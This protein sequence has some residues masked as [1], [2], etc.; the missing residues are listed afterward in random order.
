[1]RQRAIRLHRN[2]LPLGARN[3]ASA[4][5]D[6][7]APSTALALTNTLTTDYEGSSRL[8]LSYSGSFS[9][10]P[11]AIGAGDF[12]VDLWVYQSN[13]SGYRGIFSIPK[14]SSANFICRAYAGNLYIGNSP[15]NIGSF[16]PLVWTHLAVCR[17]D[18]ILYA[19]LDGIL[20]AAFADTNNYD[21]KQ[22]FLGSDWDATNYFAGHINFF[23]LTL[24]SRWTRDFTP[25]RRINAFG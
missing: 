4:Y 24:A 23:R 15:T 14:T 1:M 12:T 16:P 19:F 20:K 11:F 13:A 10:V 3:R 21:G 17:K 25:P 7:Y 6:P 22:V 5:C 8:L 9:V 18:G 2:L